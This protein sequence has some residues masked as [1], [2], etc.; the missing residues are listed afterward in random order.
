MTTDEN[1]FELVVYKIKD[2]K[3]NH[4]TSKGLDEFRAFIQ[5]FDGL[6]KPQTYSSNKEE[7]VF[8]D[9]VH[10]ES[11]AHALKA[12]E[13]FK[14]LEKDPKHAEMLGVFEEIRMF[15]HFSFLK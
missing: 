6:I 5:Q 11:S 8:M 15:E 12:A 14:E 13:A 7:G 9:I 10:W 3:I 1:V 4:F 2:D